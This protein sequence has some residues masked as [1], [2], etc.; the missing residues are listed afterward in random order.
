[1]PGYPRR[2]TE[3]HAILEEAEHDADSIVS[4]HNGSKELSYG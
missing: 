2:N 1:M 3:Y 4:W